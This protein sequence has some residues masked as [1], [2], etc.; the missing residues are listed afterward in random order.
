MIKEFN[1]GGKALTLSANAG[2]PVRYKMTFAGDLLKDISSKE[3]AT[4]EL[5]DTVS[6]LTYI[7]NKQALGETSD[8]SFE[9]YLEWLEQIEDPT[10]FLTHSVDIITFY[11]QNVKTGSKVKNPKGPRNAK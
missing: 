11:L 1:L 3:S 7:M 6:Q 9:N 8:L 2:T 5:P 10:V 4:E